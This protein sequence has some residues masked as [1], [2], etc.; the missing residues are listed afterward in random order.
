[1]DKKL[2]DTKFFEY[3]L[4]FTNWIILKKFLSCVLIASLVFILLNT[5]R[6]GWKITFLQIVGLIFIGIFFTLSLVLLNFTFHKIIPS[7]K[8]SNKK[9]EKGHIW[10]L[11]LFADSYSS[12]NY[13]NRVY[14]FSILVL[15]IGVFISIYTL[16]L[17]FFSIGYS[18]S[19]LFNSIFIGESILQVLTYISLLLILITILIT[20][21]YYFLYL[22]NITEKDVLSHIYTHWNEIENNKLRMKYLQTVYLQQ[23][24]DYRLKL[25]SSKLRY[26]SQEILIRISD[27]FDNIGLCLLTEK[28]I[29]QEYIP[30][31]HS[32][33]M[34]NDYQT[35]LKFVNTVHNK[36][37][38]NK[39]FKAHL[40]VLTSINKN[41]TDKLSLFELN[42]QLKNVKIPFL[43]Y[44]L[45][46]NE[47][48]N[49][50]EQTWIGKVIFLI[51]VFLSLYYSGLLKIELIASIFNLLKEFKSL[52]PF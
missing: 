22:S 41:I 33:I 23:I 27:Y 43:K 51:I 26:F 18:M 5:F 37:K 40:N 28:E 52:F 13:I 29:N 21:T 25:S 15:V 3:G 9:I 12:L 45:P 49:F 1:M 35:L 24:K 17:T 36:C 14:N 38:R 42:T 47:I 7:I 2:D 31:L 44:R 16:F 34:K 19:A 32:S 50:F 30:A 20:I 39:T 8:E 6:T 4:K 10:F 48:L 46:L 11:D